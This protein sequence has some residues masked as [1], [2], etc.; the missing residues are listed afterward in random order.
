MSN[1]V[2][3]D[4]FL[5][6]AERIKGSIIR[7]GQCQC[8]KETCVSWCSTCFQI[9]NDLCLRGS[10]FALTGMDEDLRRG[11][12]S[13]ELPCPYD[14]NLCVIADGHWYHG[15]CALG[16]PFVNKQAALR[17]HRHPTGSGSASRP[18]SPSGTTLNMARRPA[19]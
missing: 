11:H 12:E 4:S 13:G 8:G 5:R 17:L 18:A 9:G 6:L 16:S 10:T 1:P 19:R 15:D 7:Y 2:S 3:Q 14:S